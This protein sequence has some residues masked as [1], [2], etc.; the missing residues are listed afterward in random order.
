MFFDSLWG[1][2]TSKKKGNVPQGEA[3]SVRVSTRGVR[4]ASDVMMGKQN[5]P[6]RPSAEPQPGHF[7]G[8]KSKFFV[9]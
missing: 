8:P 1:R 6:P 7:Y 4:A 2:R 3:V 9:K 5:T